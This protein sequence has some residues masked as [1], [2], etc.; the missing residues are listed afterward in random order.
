MMTSE[1][2]G[3]V[4]VLRINPRLVQTKQALYHLSCIYSLKSRIIIKQTSLKLP[5]EEVVCLCLKLKTIHSY[6]HVCMQGMYVKINA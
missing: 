2:L 5:K 1:P 3:L 6:W 4:Y